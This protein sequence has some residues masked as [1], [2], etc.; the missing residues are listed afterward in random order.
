MIPFARQIS[1]ITSNGTFKLHIKRMRRRLSNL[2][3]FLPFQIAFNGVHFTEFHHRLPYNSVTNL[4]IDGQVTIGLISYE[5]GP[6]A[7]GAVGGVGGFAP[8][9]HHSPSAPH[10]TPP[11]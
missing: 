9:M 11:G 1:L 6:S 5:G 4:A 8:P 3:H 2:I 10:H 7:P